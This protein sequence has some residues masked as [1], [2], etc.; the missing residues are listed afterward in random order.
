MKKKRN[1][2]AF[3]HFSVTHAKNALKTSTYWGLTYTALYSNFDY[4]Y[5]IYINKE[6][7][8]PGKTQMFV[9]GINLFTYQLQN[10]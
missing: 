6:I 2:L 10:N 7:M 9:E 8:V 1:K 4:N 5:L 3:L